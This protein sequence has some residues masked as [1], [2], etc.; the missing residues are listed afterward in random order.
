MSIGLFNASAVIHGELMEG[1]LLEVWLVK[2]S[3]V[4]ASQMPPPTHVAA[5]PRT[6]PFVE[7]S[8]PF[9]KEACLCE[10]RWRLCINVTRIRA[11]LQPNE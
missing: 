2:H 5:M 1:Q 3:T 4:I 11:P 10:K 7:H 6:L 8:T 9:K